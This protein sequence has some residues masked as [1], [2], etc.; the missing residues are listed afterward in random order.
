MR[1]PVVR[2]VSVASMLALFLYGCGGRGTDLTASGPFDPLE[3][4]LQQG[5]LKVFGVNESGLNPLGSTIRLQLV[6]SKFSSNGFGYEL[7]VNGVSVPFTAPATETDTLDVPVALGEGKNEI[8][9][10]AYED[11]GRPVFYRRTLYAGGNTLR[12][13]VVDDAGALVTTTGTVTLSLSDAPAIRVNGSPTGGEAVI[14]NVPSRTII[15]D[16]RMSDGTSGVGGGFGADGVITVRVA[17]L[18]V[19]SATKNQDFSQGLAG[20]TVSGPSVT[21][22]PHVEG[23]SGTASR[24]LRQPLERNAENNRLL[25]EW[26]RTPRGRDIPDN[27]LQVVT[28]GEGFVSAYTTFNTEPGTEVVTVRYRFITSEVPGGYFGTEYNDIYSI[29]LASRAGGTRGDNNTM[30]G[31]G[32][33]AFDANGATEWKTVSVAT[34][35]AGDTVRINPAVSN[36]G[37]SAF[38]S[39]LVV[40]FVR[41]EKPEVTQSLAWNPSSGG[42]VLKYNVGVEELARD[43]QV[44]LFWAKGSTYAERIGSSFFTYVIP[45]GTKRGDGTPVPLPMDELLKG[46]DESLFVLAAIGT[47]KV[48]SIEDAKITFDT[49]AD[50]AKVPAKLTKDLRNGM[51]KAGQSEIVITSTARTP[52]DQ[53]RAM[54]QNLTSAADTIA[55]NITAQL[56]IYAKA[57]DDV[58]NVFRGA[59]NGKSREEVLRQAES[60]QSAMQDKIESVGPSNVSN[61]CADATKLAVIDVGTATFQQNAA[62]FKDY[63]SPLVTKFLDEA[64]PNRC[65]HLELKLD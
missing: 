55:N 29:T 44:K 40:D 46:P 4:F 49:N 9:L 30:N 16:A 25:Q 28:A 2:L 47:D 5:S 57:G 23:T 21:I 64:S 37:D 53:A 6:G 24:S 8:D 26:W 22:V 39:M 7:K 17:G 32:L 45:K 38:D 63:V 60:I 36:V 51:R 34:D 50:S 65:F 56:A 41:E 33:A 13:R 11:N 42:M 3:T 19:V 20:W 35:P 1:S 14:E 59:S 48:V 31:L 54:F 15:L 10:K 62:L 18:G 12:V 27:D 61:H 58:I 43:V 52:A